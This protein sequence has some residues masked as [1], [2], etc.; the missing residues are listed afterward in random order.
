MTDPQPEPEGQLYEFT[1]TASA[2]VTHHQ[3][4]EETP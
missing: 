2:E 3:E 1:I 4:D